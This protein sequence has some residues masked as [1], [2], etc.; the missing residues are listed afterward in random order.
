M[1]VLVW[2]VKPETTVYSVV[3][4]SIINKQ[5]SKNML[6]IST[7]YMLYVLIVSIG[8]ICRFLMRKK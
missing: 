7:K 5:H 6:Q 2:A 8:N 1:M 3:G 4:S